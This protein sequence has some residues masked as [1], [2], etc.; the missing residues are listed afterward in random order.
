MTTKHRP[1]PVFAG[2][3]ALAALAWCFVDCSC[4]PAQSSRD[5]GPS[6]RDER[7]PD[8]APKKNSRKHRRKGRKDRRSPTKLP[9]GVPEKVALVLK[10]VDDN[11]R[12]P[13]G[14]VGGRTF[15]NREKRLPRSDKA[16]RPIR[17]REWDVN[18]KVRGR[19][20]GAERLVTGSDRSAYYTADHYRTFIKIR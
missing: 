3:L 13:Q 7:G 19:N 2:L 10:H 20:R 9:G 1:Q 16:G 12:A 17:Y 14:Y 8:A 6:V 15:A 11:G 4:S 5:S 18:P